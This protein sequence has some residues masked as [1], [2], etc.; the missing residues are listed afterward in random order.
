MQATM[1]LPGYMDPMSVRALTVPDLTGDIF[2]VLYSSVSNWVYLGTDIPNTT[3]IMYINDV[4]SVVSPESEI[5]M[6][7]DDIAL[8][9]IIMTSSDY[10]VLQGDVDSIGSVV[11]CKYLE[12]NAAALQKMDGCFDNN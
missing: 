6:F 11:T 9:W 10:T 12:F 5:N 3:L 2:L 4:A 8:Y 7:A 1:Q